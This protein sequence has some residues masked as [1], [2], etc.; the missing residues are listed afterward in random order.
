MFFVIVAADATPATSS[1]A[2]AA[3]TAIEIRTTRLCLT[4]S[5]PYGFD[6]PQLWDSDA[7]SPNADRVAIILGP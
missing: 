1:A 3:A 4:V 5:P 7:G 2:I 6:R